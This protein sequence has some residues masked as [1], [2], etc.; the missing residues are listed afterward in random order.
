MDE[1]LRAERDYGRFG[2]FLHRFGNRR[3]RKLE[4]RV[5]PKN[6]RVERRSERVEGVKRQTKGLHFLA[7]QTDADSETTDGFWVL[8]DVKGAQF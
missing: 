2:K 6:Q 8:Q 3:E 7:I 1:R 4:L 5:L